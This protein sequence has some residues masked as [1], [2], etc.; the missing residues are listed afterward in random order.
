M[1]SVDVGV[2]M[3]GGFPTH[4]DPGALFAVLVV[5]AA[6]LPTRWGT[7]A[8]VVVS[9]RSKWSAVPVCKR[10]SRGLP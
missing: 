8:L 5:A 2:V 1:V 3:L 4:L 7:T 10:P 6:G 9:V